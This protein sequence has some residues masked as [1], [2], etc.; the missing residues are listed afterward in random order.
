MAAPVPAARRRVVLI[1]GTATDGRVWAG[2]A[3]ALGPGYEVE[4][5]TRPQS[6]DLDTEVAFLAPRCAGAIVAGVSGGATLGL[7]L[8]ARGVPFTAAVLHEP[9][10]GSL[11]PGLLAPVAAAFADGGTGA[12]ARTLYG[13]SWHEGRTT[14]DTGTIAAELRMFRAF[15]PRPL[16]DSIAD[17]V[18]LTVGADSP[19]PRHRADAALTALLGVRTRVVPG[20]HALHL[21]H[22][23][24]LAALIAEIAEPR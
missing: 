5:P 19:E 18:L 9:A 10:A 13:Q 15:E 7:E 14:A 21:D 3:A 11:V 20:A 4:C 2:V 6:G 17:R 23:T 12:F 22:P 1:H 24:A 8:A 16:P